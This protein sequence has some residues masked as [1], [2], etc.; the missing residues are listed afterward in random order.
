MFWHK[1]QD[2]D[3][4][5]EEA[6]P[7]KKSQFLRVFKYLSLFL[8]LIF[9]AI[10]A[11][12]AWLTQSQAGLDWLRTT[13]NSLLEDKKPLAFRI[14]SLEGCL[15]FNFTFGLEASD[16]QGRWLAAPR[17]SIV[18]DWRKL[19]GTIQ[20]K[21]I[22]AA[23]VDL[24]RF[25]QLPPAA[26][27]EKKE[28]PLTVKEVQD[29]LGQ[30][31][32]FL[33]RSHWWLPDIRFDEISVAAQLPESLLPASG[34]DPQ[35]LALDAALTAKVVANT[36]EAGLKAALKNALASQIQ[37]SALDL[38]SLDLNIHLAAG[39]QK[40]GLAV[41]L[42]LEALAV[43]PTLQLRDFPGKLLGDEMR[44]EL[45]LGSNTS[46]QDAQ[47]SLKGPNLK[48]GQISLA[49]N[50]YWQSDASWR[51]GRIAGPCKYDLALTFSPGI[52]QQDSPL[53]A[54]KTPVELKLGLEGD[55]PTLN[56]DLGLACADI[57]EKG[58]AVKDTRLAL[59]ARG[60]NVPYNSEALQKLEQE[61]S[62]DLRM[63][64]AVDG[65][66]IA[67]ATKLFFQAL[68]DAVKGRG[69]SS[70]RVGLRDFTLQAPGAD[71]QG[72]VVAF[73]PVGKK[74]GLDGSLDFRISDWKALGRFL[75]GQTVSGEVSIAMALSSGLSGAYADAMRPVADA[76]SPI[77][78]QNAQ[79]AAI[80]LK[81]P[82]IGLKSGK[83]QVFEGS[84]ING[85]INLENI[86]DDLG[87]KASLTASR[88][89]AAG[90]KL[91]AELNADGHL[92]G[93]MN[94]SMTSKGSVNAKVGAQWK[95]GF[96]TLGTLDVMA[97]LS[98]LLKKRGKMLAGIRSSGPAQLEYGDKGLK[99]S[100]LDVRILPSG[101]LQANGGVAPD[102][103]DL[104]L[105]LENLDF[106]PWQ[107][108]V[109]ALPAG[110]ASLAADLSGTPKSPSGNFR[111]G[112]KK[113]VVP[114]VALAPVSFSLVGAIERGGGANAL[115]TRLDLDPQTVK[116]LGG[117]V[118]QVAASVPLLFG[119]DGVPALDMKGPLSAKVRWDGALGPL[120]NLV[121]V[122]DMRLNG[123]V[124][125]DITASGSLV[126]PKVA[127]YVAVNKARYENVQ[128]GVLLTDINL[129]VDLDDAGIGSK[130]A[131]GALDSL[132]G[133]M[134]LALSV[135]DGRGGTLTANGGGGLDGSGLDINAKIN[136]LRP[137]RR[138]DIHVEL[139]GQIG[140]KGSALAPLIGGEI[141][142][143]KG[144]VL[145]N[146]LEM[147][148]SVTTLDITQPGA[149]V[150]TSPP[151]QA[152]A[153]GGRLNVRVRMLP[154][155]S[156]EGRGLA[157][158]WQANLLI[159]GPLTNPQVTGN[160]SSVR[161]NFDF[162]GKVFALTRG[163]VFFGG[164]ALSNP[165]LDI[166]LT[167][168]TPDLIAHILVTGPVNKI[169]IR[170]T[171]DPAVP[172]DEILSRVLFGRSV[173]DL[174]RME[175][176]QLAGAVAQLAGFGG[177]S[178]L[179]GS[180]KKALGVDVLRIGTANTGSQN[181]TN[182]DTGGGT[183]VEMGKYINDYIYM[184]VQQGFAADSTAF[185]I[186][187]EITPRTNFE[188]RSEKTNTWGG[189]KWKYNY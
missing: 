182:E 95:P 181:Q 152:S 3:S 114:G 2:A 26:E 124:A 130:K 71:A 48:A 86:F 53:A 31:A 42:K 115:K 74:P 22:A 49:G 127:G 30:I 19:P 69:E 132:P 35:R 149:K 143:D 154:R 73:L 28:Q 88:L 59:T 57:E 20:F 76:T 141:L 87:L 37:A 12:G 79:T 146:N 80:K 119:K 136:D 142:V 36:A 13:A 150:E 122:A 160:I 102:R 94:V 40:D 58:H 24:Q 89:S 55:L 147:T 133:R 131:S 165:L 27:D 113:L 188:L 186:E 157:S 43:K 148:G 29:L 96:V 125:M 121:P 91:S 168:D 139:S 189:I 163:I 62:L 166:E 8:L 104:R 23:N 178:S 170:L 11:G 105:G 46:N 177:G 98:A 176:L 184:G 5:L 140:V 17:N 117:T 84:G 128:Y 169:R 158:L 34:D 21:Q 4:A 155:F 51:E 60:V 145:L 41:D 151:A 68:N 52:S 32:D 162:L 33:G 185:I 129:R 161:G 179:L 9:L 138:R 112:V 47:I 44:L 100:N 85:D 14:T 72:S 70:W 67:L 97:D 173:N 54:I 106:K 164:G 10:I 120:W 15:P 75:P 45:A 135:S 107:A 93:P 18:W 108:L 156:V 153:G 99:V 6:K 134:R 109:P 126:K 175:A 101:R 174:S 39:P 82:A 63:D 25:P 118:A 83:K 78:P 16:E 66:K 38:D 111:L 65:Q 116:T 56:L 64:T 144:E 103:L 81:I 159:A 183:T 77:L 123:R 92:K 167:H 1:K 90:L 110:S 187:I 7:R 50:G 61:N 171:S 172:R 137:L 180:A